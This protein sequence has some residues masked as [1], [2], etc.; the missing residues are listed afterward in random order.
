MILA[1]KKADRR[2]MNIAI[3]SFTRKGGVLA[4]L[5]QERLNPFSISCSSYII[6]KY[7]PDFIALRPLTSSI[8]EWTKDQFLNMD[9]IIFVSACGI[10]V[11]AI[12]PFIKDKRRDPAVIVID[13]GANFC[14]SLLSGHIGGANELTNLI[15]KVTNST[16]VIT[17]ATDINHQFSV[18]LFAVKNDLILSDMTLAKEVSSSILDGNTID[19]V[20]DF[21]I[22]GSIPEQLKYYDIKDYNEIQD[23][24]MNQCDLGICITLY[25]LQKKPFKNTLY[26]IPRIVSI[27]IGCKKDT[28]F[29]LIEEYICTI[30]KEQGLSLE[31]VRN[32]G[33]IDIKAKETGILEFAQKHNLPFLTYTPNEMNAL[34]DDFQESDFVKSITGVGNVCERAA[35]LSSNHGELIL[36][37]KAKDGVTLAL[38]YCN[39][40]ITF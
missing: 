25:P 9:A 15:S 22:D 28:P 36:K 6:P 35:I 34:P 20:S 8:Q 40:R 16:P 17:T 23:N 7:A 26:L 2:I 21:H 29:S 31:S 27:G 19:L 38:S 10:A 14:I 1:I 3:V 39:R 5:I 11:R 32:I 37:K 12:A 4:S 18:D 13:E 24:T 33:S 30:I